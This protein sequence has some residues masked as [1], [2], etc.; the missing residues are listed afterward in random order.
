MPSAVLAQRVVK[1]DEPTESIR[2]DADNNVSSIS[3]DPE[4]SIY[5]EI[6]GKPYVS[7]YFGVDYGKL[8]ESDKLTLKEIEQ[9]I[10]DT[11]FSKFL[12]NDK[13]V[14]KSLLSRIEKRLGFSDMNDPFYRIDK[15]SQ[16]IKIMGLE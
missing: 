8:E 10:R 9:K 12:K 5:E 7:D 4:F 14:A 11:I 3:T 1:N 13:S 2:A 15:I 16:Y 6:S